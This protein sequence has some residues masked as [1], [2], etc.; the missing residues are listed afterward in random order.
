M[1]TRITT[2]TSRFQHA[3][4]RGLSWFSIN[5]DIGLNIGSVRPGLKIMD[6]T[7][8]ENPAHTSILRS[9][10]TTKM[11]ALSK[12]RERF[13]YRSDQTTKTTA[14]TMYRDRLH[15]YAF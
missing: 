15:T 7:S 6:K 9:H 8:F 3:N 10:H 12:Y 13:H 11:T 1:H 2:Q 5:T 4:F 14:L